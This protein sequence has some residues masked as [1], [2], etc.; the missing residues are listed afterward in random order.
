MKQLA[1]IKGISSKILSPP[2]RYT[3]SVLSAVDIKI[4]KV[5]GGYKEL[6]SKVSDSNIDKSRPSSFWTSLSHTWSNSTLNK[7]RSGTNSL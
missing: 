6:L 7:K 1:E 2:K 3:I 5:N 4:P